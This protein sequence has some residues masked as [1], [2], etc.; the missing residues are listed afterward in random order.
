MVLGRFITRYA[1][2]FS[3]FNSM[4]PQYLSTQLQRERVRILTVIQMKFKVNF[5]KGLKHFVCVLDN[6]FYR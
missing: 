1:I 6:E 3:F 5:N 2:L 4:N